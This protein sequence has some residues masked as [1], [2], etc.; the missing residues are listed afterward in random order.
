M[1]PSTYDVLTV[2]AAP[3]GCIVVWL[4]GNHHR[5]EICRLQA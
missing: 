2:G 4:S 5:T 3:G 1:E